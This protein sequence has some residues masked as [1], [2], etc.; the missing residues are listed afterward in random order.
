MNMKEFNWEN[1]N[2]FQQ[3]SKLLSLV[4]KHANNFRE[5]NIRFTDLMYDVD[6][7]HAELVSMIEMIHNSDSYVVECFKDVTTLTFTEVLEYI[8]RDKRVLT[9]LKVRFTRIRK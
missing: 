8:A 9:H 3:M 1:V 5:T 7:N 4:E 6:V 2:K